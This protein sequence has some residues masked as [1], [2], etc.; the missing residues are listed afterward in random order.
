MNNCKFFWRQLLSA[1]RLTIPLKKPTFDR[2]RQVMT[3]S[4]TALNKLH[5]HSTLRLLTCEHLQIAASIQIEVEDIHPMYYPSTV[6]LYV[7]K[8]QLNIQ[9]EHQLYSI[10]RG[11]FA[12][13]QKYTHGQC[14][15]TWTAEEGGAH[16]VAF[17]LQDSFMQQVMEH[18]PL[19]EL[20]QPLL[21]PERVVAL[22]YDTQLKALMGSVWTYL[23]DEVQL[24]KA[25]LELKTL[26]ALL[27][28]SKVRP[29]LL[30][31]LKAYAQPERADLEAF[32]R[33]NYR[34]NIKLEEL[35]RLSG[36]SLSTFNREFKRCFG[37]SP[38][39]WIKQ[40]RLNEAK[41]LLLQTNKKPSEVY[42][43]V[44]FEDL[45]H[46][47]RSFKRQF[48]QNPSEIKQLVA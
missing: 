7:Q 29:D 23:E 48:G 34:Y 35:A 16:M 38:H 37:C 42:L 19:G 21:L 3:D 28:I 25:L 32:M 40:E 12:L 15:K 43:D 30:P 20:D 17:V 6:L 2:N 31:V 24:N 1:R 4:D 11:Q 44:G 22:P 26:E 27:A 47:S 39:R 9:L 14:F 18:L 41:R 46:F 13:I 8:G 10:P 5:H 45:A 36:R 33:H